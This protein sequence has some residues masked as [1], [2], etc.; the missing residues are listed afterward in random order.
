MIGN[1]RITFTESTNHWETRRTSML[2]KPLVINE[3]IGGAIME[4]YAYALKGSIGGRSFRPFAMPRC[5]GQCT[6]QI[7]SVGFEMTPHTEISTML[8]PLPPVETR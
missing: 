2:E 1:E 4:A 8:L 6:P 5:F 7:P 3:L